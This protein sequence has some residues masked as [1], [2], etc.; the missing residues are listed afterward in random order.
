MAE[1]LRTEHLC[2]NFSGL[3]AVDDISLSIQDDEILGIIGPNGAGKTTFFNAI[4]GF[5]APTSG[6]VYFRGEKMTKENTVKY[7]ERGVT[8]TFQNIRTFGDM[9]VLENVLVGMHKTMKANLLEI[10]LKTKKQQ[11][12]ERT[13]NEKAYEILEF[14]EIA[15]VAHE[16]S[17]SLPYGTQRKVEVARALASDPKFILLDEPTAG[18]NPHETDDLMH[19]IAKIRKRGPAVTVIEHNIGFMVTLCDR[20]AVLNFGKLLDLETPENVASNPEVIKAY[21]G[22]E[23]N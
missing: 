1:I 13:A 23:D 6:E 8:R 17:G 10:L 14:L 15:D 3:K 22:E 2:V 9:T 21:I 18:M 12:E 4:T 7:C 16:L 5:R 19:L 20:I 11:N